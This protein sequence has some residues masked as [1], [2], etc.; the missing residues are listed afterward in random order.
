M[1]FTACSNVTKYTMNNGFQS[2][3]GAENETNSIFSVVGLNCMLA[4]EFS[5]AALFNQSACTKIMCASGSSLRLN[6]VYV[7]KKVVAIINMIISIS[8]Y[9]E[10]KVNATL[11]FYTRSWLFID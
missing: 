8:L 9:S 3:I 5:H 10:R 11:T 7:I 2:F 1:G 4:E 6:R